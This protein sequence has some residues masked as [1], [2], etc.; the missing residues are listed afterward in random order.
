MSRRIEVQLLGIFREIFHLEEHVARIST[1]ENTANWDSFNGLNLVLKVEEV[2][3]VSLSIEEMNKFRSFH[4][5]LTIVQK[6]IDG[7]SS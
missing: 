5:I 6:K 3:N 7:R 2:F 1:V 4:L